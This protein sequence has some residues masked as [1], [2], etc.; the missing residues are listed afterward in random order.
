VR[1]AGGGQRREDLSRGAAT[2]RAHPHQARR[3]HARRR[4]A[5][6]QG[7]DGRPDQVHR[8]GEKTA[9]FEPFYPD[10]LAQRI[11]GMGDVV[12]LVE[13]AQE[14]ID[15]KEAEKMAEALRKGDFN[16][17]DFMAQISR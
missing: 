16:L 5:L 7:G 9:D 4:G 15:Q 8:P 12:S 1:S 10:R 2:H 17:D 3:R 14:T 11:L 13:K 6:D